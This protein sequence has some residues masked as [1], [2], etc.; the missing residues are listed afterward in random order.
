V[1]LA[2]LLSGGRPRCWRASD[3][4]GVIPGEPGEITGINARSPWSAAGSANRLYSIER[5]E[6]ERSLMLGLF[7]DRALK[8]CETAADQLEYLRAMVTKTFEEPFCQGQSRFG[9]NRGATAASECPG[10]PLARPAFG[11]S[12]EQERSCNLVKRLNELLNRKRNEL[13]EEIV[14]MTEANVKR[15]SGKHTAPSVSSGS[16]DVRARARAVALRFEAGAVD[17]MAETDAWYVSHPCVEIEY[18]KQQNRLC[19]TVVG[20]LRR[21]AADMRSVDDN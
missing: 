1:P 18:W 8:T 11:R 19:A 15:F 5:E 14:G 16:P 13:T 6:E 2:L 3:T 20:E 21:Y 4:K 7:C 10:R 9:K 17:D 12:A